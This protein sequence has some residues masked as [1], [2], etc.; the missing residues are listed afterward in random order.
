MESEL[1][2]YEAGSF[3]GA[4]AGG[5][6]GKCELADKGTIFL[7]EIGDLPMAMQAKRLRVLENGEI[8]KIGYV[9]RLHN[10]R[11]EHTGVMT[12]PVS[13]RRYR[14]SILSSVSMTARSA[15]KSETSFSRSRACSLAKTASSRVSTSSLRERA[16]VISVVVTFSRARLIYLSTTECAALK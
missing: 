1:F 8:Q 13:G 9:G 11:S 6:K 2:G 7:D 3:T 12:E 10:G 16:C 14:P 5:M 15:E 4:K